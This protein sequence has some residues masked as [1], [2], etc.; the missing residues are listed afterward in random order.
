MT[1]APTHTPGD[2]AY[3]SA[4]RVLTE[5]AVAPMRVATAAVTGWTDYVSAYLSIGPDRVPDP[6]TPLRMT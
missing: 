1:S 4:A 3:S 6:A 2:T 5:L